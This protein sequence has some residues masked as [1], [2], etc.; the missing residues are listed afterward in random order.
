MKILLIILFFIFSEIT[1]SDILHD[2]S[3]I[4]I[5]V[6][7]KGDYNTFWKTDLCIMNADTKDHNVD[8][9]FYSNDNSYGKNKELTIKANE[10][11]C[12]SNIVKT[13][14]EYEGYGLIKTSA[15]E[16]FAPIG[17]TTRIYT[18]RE[19][20]GTYGQ[21]VDDQTFNLSTK[22]SYVIGIKK[23]EDFRTNIGV[24]ILSSYYSKNFFTIEIYDKGKYIKSYSISV[25]SPGVV[26][27][28][29]DIDVECGFAKIVPEKSNIV[30][31]GYISVV[32]NKTGDAVFIPAKDLY[33]P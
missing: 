29:I 30:Y 22:I 28:P 17:V 7:K 5:A 23:N 8:L 6:Y 12:I 9:Y 13:F 3:F 14:F 26:Q 10:I 21:T 24:A 25:T 4:P 15:D 19:D 18:T 16:F 1:N 33:E 31:L 2:D 20:G 11:K 32:D 27:I